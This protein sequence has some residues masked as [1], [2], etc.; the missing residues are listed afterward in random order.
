[1][2]ALKVTGGTSGIIVDNVLGPLRWASLRYIS[3][4]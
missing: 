1:M 4:P 2:A 3:A